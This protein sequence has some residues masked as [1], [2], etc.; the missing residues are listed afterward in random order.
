MS[1]IY[2]GVHGKIIGNYNIKKLFYIGLFP[3]PRFSKDNSLN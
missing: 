3:H 1:S 2:K